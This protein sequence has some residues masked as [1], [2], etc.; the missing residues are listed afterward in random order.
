MTWGINPV[1]FTPPS[2]DEF[3]DFLQWQNQGENLGDTSVDTVN[4]SDGLSATRGVGEDANIVTIV[5]VPDGALLQWQH[6]GVD[7]GPN[8]IT[9]VN[10]TTGLNAVVNDAGDTITIS[11]DLLPHRL[12]WRVVDGDGTVTADDVD[13]GIEMR[14]NTGAPVL[15]VPEGVIPPGAAVLVFQRGA[16]DVDIIPSSGL[17]LL[18]P[19]ARFLSGLA[20]QGAIV[21]LIGG[22]ADTGEVILCG[23]MASVP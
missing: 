2:S 14:A 15:T 20:G 22:P 16:A 21:T 3:P 17:N 8:T 7:V 6:D 5:A 12:T 10:L 13:N 9:T 1:E 11:A 19:T 23:D 18:Y 4:I